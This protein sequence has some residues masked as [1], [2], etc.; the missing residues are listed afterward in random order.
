LIEK[1][2]GMLNKLN[3]PNPGVNMK[4]GIAHRGHESTVS[5]DRAPGT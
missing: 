2:G 5:L 3:F 4:F 1:S